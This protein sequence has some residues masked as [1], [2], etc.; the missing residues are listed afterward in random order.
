[1]PA[2]GDLNAY[3][4]LWRSYLAQSELQAGCAI[5]GVTVTSDSPKA[6]AQAASVFR[7]WRGRVAALL[8]QGGLA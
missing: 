5:L 6:V 4:S 3:L 7:S 8:E 1:M 2:D